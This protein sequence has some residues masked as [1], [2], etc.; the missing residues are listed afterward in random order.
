MSADQADGSRGDPSLQLGIGAAAAPAVLAFWLGIRDHGLGWLVPRCMGLAI[1]VLVSVWFVLH[2]RANPVRAPARSG[3]TQPG[4]AATPFD[5]VLPAQGDGASV[6]IWARAVAPIVVALSLGLVLPWQPTVSAVV[7]GATVVLAGLAMAGC[8]FP[9]IARRLW[10]AVGMTVSAV[11]LAGGVAAAEL[12]DESGSD[13]APTAVHCVSAADLGVPAEVATEMDRA[14]GREGGEAGCLVAMLFVSDLPVYGLL[15][16]AGY[17]VLGWNNQP[18]QGD[19]GA[20]NASVVWA[21]AFSDD[22]VRLLDADRPSDR[23]M[24]TTGAF[25]VLVD[26]GGL[27]TAVLGSDDYRQWEVVEGPLMGAYIERA[28]KIGNLPAPTGRA[29][30]TEDLVTQPVDVSGL[31]TSR[32]PPDARPVEWFQRVCH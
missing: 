17:W 22:S 5:S 11:V 8:L 25:V 30:T 6:G 15:T 7:S 2:A 16:S 29:S 3:R 23:L 19:D 27:V 26:N 32:T 1:V 9:N 14:L 20:P 4:Q 24:C 18:V 13:A 28:E 31:L 10:I 21:G 12:G